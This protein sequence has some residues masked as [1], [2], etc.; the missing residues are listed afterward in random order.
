MTVETDYALH[1]GGAEVPPRSGC[2]LAA[3]VWTI[4]VRRAHRV[5][6]QA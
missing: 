1:I 2:T 6:S 4:D 3:G 5:P